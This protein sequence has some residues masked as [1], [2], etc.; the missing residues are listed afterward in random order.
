[1]NFKSITLSL[2]FLLITTNAY[3][4]YFIFHRNGEI[5]GK[6]ASC[7]AVCS[8]NPN[9]IRVTEAEYSLYNNAQYK[10]VE[11]EI[12]DKTQEDIDADEAARIQAEADAEAA[13]LTKLDDAVTKDRSG[14]TL[15]K[16]DN[17]IDNI[18]SLEDA[19]VFLKK[20]VRY[21]ISVDTDN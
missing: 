10:V 17:A 3:A 20:L 21:V 1:M 16:V 7:G 18:G 19:K 8:N 12:V 15:T 14:I 9:A 4:G 11:G 13:R 5:V 6:R 2:I